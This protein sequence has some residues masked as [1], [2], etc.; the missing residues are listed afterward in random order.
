MRD[1]IVKVSKFINDGEIKVL[2]KYCKGNDVDWNVGGQPTDP[3][4]YN[5]V[6]Q[7]AKLLIKRTNRR[8]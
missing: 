2:S 3:I 6:I 7:A 1:V 4:R 5:R 8:V